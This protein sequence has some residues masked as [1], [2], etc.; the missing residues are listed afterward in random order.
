MSGS[1]GE[2]MVYMNVMEVRGEK[3][4]AICDQELLGARLVESDRM[5]YVDPRF[6]GGQLVPLS[7]AIREAKTATIV[8]LVGENSVS[9]AV[10]E[11]LVHP[12]AVVRIAG[13]PHAQAVKMTY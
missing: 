3:I 11:G 1:G 9:A 10:R 12:L 5:L 2:P 6:Y 4:V 8:N 7:I 13:V